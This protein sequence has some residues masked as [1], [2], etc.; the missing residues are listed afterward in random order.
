M[1]RE[2]MEI[3]CSHCPA[4]PKDETKKPGAYFF[5][6]WDM[7][8]RGQVLFVCPGCGREHART[9]KD[10]EMKS[11]DGEARFIGG[12]GKVDIYHDGGGHKPGW[13]RIVIMKSAWHRKPMLELIKV[14]P[15]G[16]L[17]EKWLLKAA[18]EKGAIP[19]DE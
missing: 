11:N 16:Y 18:K 12:T 13:D 10:G 17:S 5:V 3:Y 6:N 9:I 2:T 7:D 4:D 14:V 15:C 1:A 19:D 8:R